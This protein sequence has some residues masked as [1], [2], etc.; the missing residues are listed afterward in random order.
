M[1]MPKE[2]LCVVVY[3]VTVMHSMQAGYM[4]K[5]QK[6]SDKALTQISRLNGKSSWCGY[7][8]ACAL[9]S[10]F[11][12]PFLFVKLCLQT[13]FFGCDAVLVAEPPN[14]SPP[15]YLTLIDRVCIGS[16]L[17]ILVR[18]VFDHCSVNAPVTSVCWVC[19]IVYRYFIT[20]RS[21]NTQLQ[22]VDVWSVL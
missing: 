4:D 3:L 21:Y 14:A 13:Y 16:R 5:A 18:A 9:S 8:P 17:C 11:G 19:C 12:S 6:Y 15:I 1:W 10:E 20:H 2:E 22:G 7:P